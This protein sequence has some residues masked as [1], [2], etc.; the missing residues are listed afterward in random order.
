MWLTIC[1]C[2]QK[3]KNY[4]SYHMY[5]LFF[6]IAPNLP[7]KTVMIKCA[8]FL[9]EKL[10]DFIKQKISHNQLWVQTMHFKWWI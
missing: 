10:I 7:H 3:K 1:H 8:F 5:W 4:L 9:A 6:S 2:I